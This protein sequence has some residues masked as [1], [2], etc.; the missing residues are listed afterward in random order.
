MKNTKLKIKS[1]FTSS[2]FIIG[3][4]VSTATIAS[5]QVREFQAVEQPW[6]FKLGVTA[7]GLGLIALELWWV[8]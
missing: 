2:L 6:F 3:F 5:A 8:S 7:I 4:L 1:F